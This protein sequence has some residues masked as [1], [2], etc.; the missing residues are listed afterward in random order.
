MKFILDIKERYLKVQKPLVYLF[1]F[2]GVLG[3]VIGWQ[4]LQLSAI[5]AMAFIVL[6]VLFEIHSEL[7]NYQKISSTIYDDYNTAFPEMQRVIEEQ[8][9]KEKR[10]SL[11]WLGTCMDIG[12]LFIKRYLIEEVM[13]KGENITIEIEIA[14][15]DPAWKDFDSVNP[16]WKTETKSRYEEIEKFIVEHSNMNSTTK[17]N[18]KLST[19]DHMPS[20]TG[21]FVDDKYLFLAICQWDK[22]RY[23]VGKN[24]YTLYKKD[25]DQKSQKKIYQYKDWFAFCSRSN[26]PANP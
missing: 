6:Q 26:T 4:P 18:I 16:F 10:V 20:Y 9:R 12:W 5:L 14:M 24:S 3:S 8:I 2:I 1:L 11:K 25:G 13:S 21:L 19:Y 15:L 17:V 22:G 23:G 7:V